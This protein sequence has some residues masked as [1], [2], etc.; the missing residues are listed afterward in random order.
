MP[1]WS[2]AKMSSWSPNCAVH[3]QENMGCRGPCPTVIP[4]AA[5]GRPGYDSTAHV[6]RQHGAGRLHFRDILAEA[7]ELP[8]VDVPMG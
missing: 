3:S 8:A 1:L 6:G 5:D 2:V 4:M 7:R